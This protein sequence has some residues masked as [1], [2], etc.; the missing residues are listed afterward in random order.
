MISFS[1]APNGLYKLSIRTILT[2]LLIDH[3]NPLWTERIFFDSDPDIIG[4]NLS[5]RYLQ[6][7]NR[8]S[9]S[10]L[11][12]KKIAPSVRQRYGILLEARY[13]TSPIFLSADDQDTPK[14]QAIPHYARRGSNTS[15]CRICYGRLFWLV[16]RA[17]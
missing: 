14:N 9:T 11:C 10:T 3:E 4:P 7:E 5:F 6:V 12:K 16:Q 15:P 13:P 1:L 8:F 2:L 17:S